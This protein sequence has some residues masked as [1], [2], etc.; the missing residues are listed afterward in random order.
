MNYPVDLKT[1]QPAIIKKSKGHGKK[2]KEHGTKNEGT[3]RKSSSKK[4][5]P[6]IPRIRHNYV[7][8]RNNYTAHT[9]S[10]QIK[11]VPFVCGQSI[12]KTH[13]IGLKIQETLNAIKQEKVKNNPTYKAQIPRVYTHNY[14]QVQ[15]HSPD[16][17]PVTLRPTPTVKRK[18]VDMGLLKVVF[19]DLYEELTKMMEELRGLR[20]SKRGNDTVSM[21]EVLEHRIRKKE[22][23]ISVTMALY[24]EVMCLRKALGLKQDKSIKTKHLPF[25]D[26]ISRRAMLQ[27]SYKE[28]QGGDH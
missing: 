26:D 16:V 22:M 1:Q 9:Y 12:S 5:Q 25:S 21:M 10:S 11:A 4:S 27:K 3:K 19:L 20:N 8:M 15:T 28:F 6:W 17:K 13:N 14:V 24:K 18:P 23:Q 7:P 2:G